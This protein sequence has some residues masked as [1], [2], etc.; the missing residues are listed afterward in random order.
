MSTHIERD[1]RRV[2]QLR[3]AEAN[4]LPAK[5]GNAQQKVTY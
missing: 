2:P 1:V 4:V 5:D 3:E